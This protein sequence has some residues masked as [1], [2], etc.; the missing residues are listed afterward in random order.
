MEL[1]HGEM[2][3]AMNQNIDRARHWL[4]AGYPMETLGALSH[5]KRALEWA[6][7]IHEQELARRAAERAERDEA[8][9]G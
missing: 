2:V 8:L 1:N 7:R 6:E 9:N 4:S 5:M 3:A